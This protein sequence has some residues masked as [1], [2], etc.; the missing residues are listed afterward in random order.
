MYRWRVTFF[1]KTPARHLGSIAAQDEA[2]ARAKAIDLF[3]I[4]PSQEFRL[5]VVNV[6]RITTGNVKTKQAAKAD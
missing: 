1:T 3:G 4:E 5:V 6:G 2:E